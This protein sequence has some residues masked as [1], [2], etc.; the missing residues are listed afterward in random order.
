VFDV[1][2]RLVALSSFDVAWLSDEPRRGRVLRVAPLSVGGLLR[3]ALFTG[4]AVVLTS[5]TMTL[6]G[7]FA[8]MARSMGLG[9]GPADH[10]P[11]GEGLLGPRWNALDVGSPFAYER[12]GILYTARHLPRPGREGLTDQV[13]DELAG[14]IEAAGGRTLG[15]FSSRRAALQATEG[16]SSRLDLP[17]LSQWDDSLPEVIRHFTDDPRTSLFGTL[18]LWQ[19]VDVPGSSCSLVVIDRI[20]FPRPDDPLV[21]ARQ[22]AVDDGGGNGFM[23]VSVPRA[24]LLLAQGVGRLIRSDDDRGVVAVLDSRLATA[25]YGGFLRASLP[26]FWWTTDRDQVKRS[27]NSLRDAASAAEATQ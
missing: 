3:E 17:V 1:A 10:D 2:E 27:L 18:S 24:A 13:L 25:G 21:S 15:L 22:Q 16:I 5:A 9:P 20:P 11:K 6:G 26:P 19:G 8:P 12:Q 14:L 23:A 4:N 7:S